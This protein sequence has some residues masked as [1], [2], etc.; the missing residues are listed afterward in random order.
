MTDQPAKISMPVDAQ[1]P[2][3]VPLFGVVLA[4]MAI[5]AI[6]GFTGYAVGFLVFCFIPVAW[7]VR[8]INPQAAYGISVLCA[9]V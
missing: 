3:L 2:W 9:T 4:V 7:T 6:E 8:H 1:R 5:G